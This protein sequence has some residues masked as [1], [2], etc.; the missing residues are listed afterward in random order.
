VPYEASSQDLPIEHLT[1]NLRLMDEGASTRD[2]NEKANSAAV[3]ES[4]QAPPAKKSKVEE[5]TEGTNAK[6]EVTQEE[7]QSL[8]VKAYLTKTL[9][10]LLSQGMQRIA[11]ER[12]EDPVDFLADFLKQNNPNRKT[13]Q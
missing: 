13:R 8:P 9:V 2:D 4:D 7:L 1:S 3:G 5:P 6:A 10:P 11:S 12:P